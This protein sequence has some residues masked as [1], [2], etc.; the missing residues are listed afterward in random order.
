MAGPA[1]IV[2]YHGFIPS[3]MYL[4]P[5]KLYQ[6]T[7]RLIKILAADF[8]FQIPIFGYIA[9]QC[10]GVP[11]DRGAALR[12]LQE[13]NIVLVSPGGVAEA[14]AG[15]QND[16]MLQWGTRKGFAEIA[17]RAGV[18]VIP[19]FTRNIR[20]VFITLMASTR[21]VQW[22]YQVT[23]LPFAF[24]FGP[25]PVPLTTVLGS[26]EYRYNCQLNAALGKPLESL[27]NEAPELFVRRVAT[28]I[29]SLMMSEQFSQLP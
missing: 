19:M 5:V 18:P 7:G 11:A 3:D 6:Q 9:S 26:V 16:Y 28:K 23:K 24:F 10:G 12:L 14:I 29:N 22:L 15:A 17:Q 2:C 20:H 21:L 13:G 25:F 27:P 1:L 4:L 8:V